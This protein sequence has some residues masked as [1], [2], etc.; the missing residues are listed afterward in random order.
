MA[1]ISCQL[2]RNISACRSGR[3]FVNTN[4]HDDPTRVIVAAYNAETYRLLYVFCAGLFVG[5]A[6]NKI[7]EVWQ[8]ISRKRVVETGRIFAGSY[9]G[10]ELMYSTT[11]TGDLKPWGSPLGNQNIEGCKKTCNDFLQ[12]GFTD[13]DEIWHDVEGL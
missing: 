11:Q 10:R 7:D 12:G 2:P 1:S 5:H 9:R 3:H 13:L 6:G 8:Q 4:Q